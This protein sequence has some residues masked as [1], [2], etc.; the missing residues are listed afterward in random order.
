MALGHLAQH[1]APSGDELEEF[2]LSERLEAEA[3]IYGLLMQLVWA[4]LVG[5]RPALAIWSGD[6]LL[7]ALGFWDKFQRQVLWPI[8]E[9]LMAAAERQGKP[10][11]FQAPQE[12][13]THPDYQTR[14]G[15]LEA[16]LRLKLGE[17]ASPSSEIEIGYSMV[18]RTD[19]FLAALWK[20][21]RGSFQDL[22]TAALSKH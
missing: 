22:I 21:G 13:R 14:R 3:D 20:S 9:V 6:F 7:G 8:A 10:K 12:R 1:V 5:V 19:E 2:T 17:S 16:A 4:D 11:F 18:S 15:L